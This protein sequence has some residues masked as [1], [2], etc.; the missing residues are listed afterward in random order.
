M[1]GIVGLITKMSSDRAEAELHRMLQPLLH[2]PSYITG[3]WVDESLGVYLG[4]PFGR[5]PSPTGCPSGTNDGT[6]CSCFPEKNFQSQTRF[7]NSKRGD[8]MLSPK[9]LH[10]L[11][12]SP[13]RIPP[14]PQV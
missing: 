12:T 3:T 8:M 1:P 9:V 11:F 5:I 10:I 4:W 6:S 2:Q 13:K 14:F 7:M